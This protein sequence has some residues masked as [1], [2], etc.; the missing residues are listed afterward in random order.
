MDLHT[1]CCNRA[2]LPR[3]QLSLLDVSPRVRATMS[4]FARPVFAR[5]LRAPTCLRD[6]ACLRDATCFRGSVFVRPRVFHLR[7]VFACPR[8]F[9]T[10]WVLARPVF[11]KCLRPASAFATTRVFAR[12]VFGTRLRPPAC[13]HDDACPCPTC[14][15]NVS[16][17]AQVCSR[18]RVPSPSLSS[19]IVFSG[20]HGFTYGS[21]LARAVRSR[22]SCAPPRRPQ[23]NSNINGNDNRNSRNYDSTVIIVI[24]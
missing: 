23:C 5:C 17:H 24:I 9:P 21:A 20:S 14:F 7:S 6:D 12:P 3:L 15:R 1:A 13:L 11:G 16:S 10:T 18:R 2:S 4:V 19:A 8:V 22:V